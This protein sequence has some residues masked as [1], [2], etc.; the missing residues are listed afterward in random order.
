MH[1]CVVC[2]PKQQRRGS[3]LG[4]RMSLLKTA[5]S[6]WVIQNNY[7]IHHAVDKVDTEER[8]RV[9]KTSATDHKITS[10][11][12]LDEEKHGNQYLC[13]IFSEKISNTTLGCTVMYFL[14]I[15]NMFCVICSNV[16]DL[17]LS[18]YI[19]TVLC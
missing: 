6:L 17:S 15:R 12:N 16:F 14:R 4:A 1:C 11:I 13:C 8:Q 10:V 3:Q 2:R 5:G 9:S 18:I 19:L 7:K